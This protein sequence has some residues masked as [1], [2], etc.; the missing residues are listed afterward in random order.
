MRDH[1]HLCC[2]AAYTAVLNRC[3]WKDGKGVVSFTKEQ[4]VK[5]RADKKYK[6]AFGLSAEQCALGG[7]T[8]WK[9][10][11]KVYRSAVNMSSTGVVNMSSTGVAVQR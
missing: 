4:L 9:D 10:S 7:R 1:T 8:D 2:A 11:T 5:W 3:W 6:N